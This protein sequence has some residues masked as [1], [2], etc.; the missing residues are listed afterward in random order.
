MIIKKGSKGLF[1]VQMLTIL[2]S[3]LIVLGIPLKGEAKTQVDPWI[4]GGEPAHPGDFPFM[5]SLQRKF[6]GHYC[7]GSLID[8]EWVLTAAHCVVSSKPDKIVAGVTRLSDEENQG[9]TAQVVQVIIHPNFN[10]AN[11]DND[12][13][14]LKLDQPLNIEKARVLARSLNNPVTQWDNKPFVWV[15]GWG[16]TK[17]GSY[18][19]SDDLLKVKLP[20][21]KWDQ[22]KR[23]YGN[24]LTKNMIC[25]GYDKGGYDSCQ[26]DS[27]GPLMVYFNRHVYLVGIVSWG[28]GCAR[29][30]KYG[31]YTNLYNYI[32]WI[33][34]Y[35]PH[36]GLN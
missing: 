34:S 22:C 21:V 17:E 32:D 4:V 33:Q 25:A 11:L 19:I 5:V 3:F 13:A 30:K 18:K 7:G 1:I 9:V 15:A 35:V 10:R 14:L 16:V 31:V 27:G 2:A 26:G 12:I 24:D 20:F 28:H 23:V 29:P 6:F 8:P 36:V